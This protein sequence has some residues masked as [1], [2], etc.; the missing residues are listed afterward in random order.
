MIRCLLKEKPVYG[1]GA[2]LQG[3]ADRSSAEPSYPRD[4][5][6]SGV[7]QPHSINCIQTSTHKDRTYNPRAAP[8]SSPLLPLATFDVFPDVSPLQPAA[9]LATFR[10][11]RRHPINTSESRR[12]GAQR[13]A[14]CPLHSCPVPFSHFKEFG[15]ITCSCLHGSSSSGR[16]GQARLRELLTAVAPRWQPAGALCRYYFYLFI[17]ADARGLGGEGN[18]GIRNIR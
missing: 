10:R 17:P 7:N 9:P 16:L 12:L 8:P 3:S 5:G 6:R 15:E 1:C 14:L 4:A 11:A 2:R 13:S 18:G